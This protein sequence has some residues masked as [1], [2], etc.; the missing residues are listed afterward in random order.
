MNFPA[1]CAA[2]LARTGI[3]HA[4]RTLQAM[5][6]RDGPRGSIA[7]LWSQRKDPKVDGFHKEGHSQTSL[8]RLQ[9]CIG[10]PQSRYNPLMELDFQSA[11]TWLLGPE[12]INAKHPGHLWPRW[13]FL[14]ALGLIYF[15]AFYSLLFQIKGLIGP[16]GILPATD[17][18]KAVAAA[19]PTQKFWFA[20]TLFWFSAGDRGRRNMRR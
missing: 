18:L 15:S 12:P 5:R 13:I 2:S 8:P 1:L 6:R 7:I 4:K 14:R 20:P 16:N 3:S 19:L 11:S 9:V 17:Y 10:L